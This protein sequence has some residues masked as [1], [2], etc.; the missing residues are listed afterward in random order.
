M[1]KILIVFSVALLFQFMIVQAAERGSVPQVLVKAFAARFPEGQ[2][3]KWE[4]RQE[5]Y[6][7]TFR[8]DGKTLHAYF[9]AAGDWKGTETPVKWT[10]H[11]PENVQAGWKQSEYAGW[12]VESIRKIETP[13]QPLYALHVNNSPV[14]N[15]E[16]I[17]A[18]LE[19]HVVFFNANGETVR[20]DR[21]P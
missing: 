7:A 3:Q 4:T 9:T 8:Q 16:R 20:K 12:Y 17:D 1:K 19:E 10:K 21:M 13:E 14:L 5:G 6:I 15:S 2:L 11:L 18:Y